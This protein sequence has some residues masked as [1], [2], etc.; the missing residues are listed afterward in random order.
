MQM[1]MLELAILL[2]FGYSYG[3]SQHKLLR[4]GCNGV[5]FQ[6]EIFPGVHELEVQLRIVFEIIVIHNIN[7]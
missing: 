4:I 1:F 6:F 2:I 5:D 3:Y 7:Y